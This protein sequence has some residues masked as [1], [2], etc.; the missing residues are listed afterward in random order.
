MFNS[1]ATS[2]GDQKLK[3]KLKQKAIYSYPTD[4][5][6]KALFGFHGLEPWNS[7]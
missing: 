7:S 5:L 1:F 3:K 2:S 4:G 6:S